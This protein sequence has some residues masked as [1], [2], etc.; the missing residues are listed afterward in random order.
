MTD[1]EHTVST[2]RDVLL[3]ATDSY[4]VLLAA[5]RRRCVEEIDEAGADMDEIDTAFDAY[6]ERVRGIM[7]P[8]G[9]A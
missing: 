3:A 6:K 4:L 5:A 7:R 1:K 8:R 2:P 9:T